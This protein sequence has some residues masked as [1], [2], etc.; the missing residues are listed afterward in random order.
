MFGCLLF[1]SSVHGD[2]YPLD[3]GYTGAQPEHAS[4]KVGAMGGSC[5]QCQVTRPLLVAVS[6]GG[7]GAEDSRLHLVAGPLA[8]EVIPMVVGA[9][10]KAF[11]SSRVCTFPGR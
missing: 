2:C 3:R 11:G 1:L 9:V 6:L 10:S 4:K 8:V 5:W 7:G